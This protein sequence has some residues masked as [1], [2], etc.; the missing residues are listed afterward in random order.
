MRAHDF[1]S[2]VVTY[3]KT[4]E[5]ACERASEFYDTT[6]RVNKNRTKHFPC[7]NLFI[8]LVLKLTFTHELVERRGLKYYLIILFRIL[9]SNTPGKPGY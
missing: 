5:R 4:K 2:R 8:L 7:C 1:Y 6:Q 3:H 9:E